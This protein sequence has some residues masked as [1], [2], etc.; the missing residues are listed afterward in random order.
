[1]DVTSPKSRLAYQMHFDI[2]DRAMSDPKG[3]RIKMEDA[4]KAW[5]LRL[6]F[7]HARDL[8]RKDNAQTYDPGH[9]LHGH[10]I[11]DQLLVTIENDED[12]VWLYVHK[13]DASRLY[14]EDL[15]AATEAAPVEEVE[16]R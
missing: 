13:R 6:E 10:S 14:I 5:R 16:R 2:L 15:S 3:I 8:D 7:H 1:M 4:G 11:Y 12:Q 9:T